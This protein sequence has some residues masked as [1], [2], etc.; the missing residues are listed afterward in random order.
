VF[1]APVLVSFTADGAGTTVGV[2]VEV[3]VRPRESLDWYVT[4][5]AVPVN[6]PVHAGDITGVF[7]PVHGVNV[8]VVLET[9][10]DPSPDT[11]SDV[12]VQFGYT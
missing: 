8:T 5:D 6:A 2:I 9:E 11:T 12:A 1:H 4:A 10:Y 7:T 3:A